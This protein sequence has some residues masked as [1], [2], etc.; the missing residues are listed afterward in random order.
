MI[1]VNNCHEISCRL[2][3]INMARQ[4][5]VR[6]FRD[7]QTNT[8]LKDK[9]NGADSLEQLVTMAREDGYDVTLEEW[10]DATQFKVEEV[11]SPLSEIP[12]I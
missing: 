11:E 10:L 1:G 9:Y 4:E 5:V 7:V 3:G 8:A 12:G 2:E 6:L